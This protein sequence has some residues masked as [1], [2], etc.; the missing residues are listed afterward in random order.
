MV[1]HQRWGALVEKNTVVHDDSLK[2]WVAAR[3]PFIG[4][5]QFPE[6]AVAQGVLSGDK[7]LAAVVYHDFQPEYSTIQL[8]IASSSTMWAKKA[9]IKALLEYPFRQLGC[10]K[11]WVSALH[12]EEHTIKT[13]EHIGFKKEAILAH[14]FGHK[15]HAW[16]GRMLL[17]DYVRLYE[18]G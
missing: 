6:E 7:V 3:I 4:I 18:N 5:D 10:Y 12:T 15:K 14:Q 9:N 16:I 17:P 13:N 2:N 11:C 8:S 1:L